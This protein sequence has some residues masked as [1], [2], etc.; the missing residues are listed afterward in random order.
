MLEEN[1][2]NEF[3]NLYFDEIPKKRTITVDHLKTE[4]N[5]FLQYLSLVDTPYLLSKPVEKKLSPGIILDSTTK[6]MEDTFFGEI[7]NHLSEFYRENGVSVPHQVYKMTKKDYMFNLLVDEGKTGVWIH[8]INNRTVPPSF[9]VH[10]NGAY[11][12]SLR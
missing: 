9:L 7:M 3:E 12:G 6:T 1:I 4:R 11:G 5:R 2:D 8:L 10:F